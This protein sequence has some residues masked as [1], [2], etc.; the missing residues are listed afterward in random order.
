MRKKKHSYCQHFSDYDVQFFDV[1]SMNIM[2]HGHYV[3]YLEMARC[4][5]LESIGYHYDV[6]KETGFG[7]PI[8]QLELKYVKPALFRQKIRIYLSLV[9]YETCIRFD[10]RIVDLET[11]ERLT[12]GSTTQVAVD[13]RKREMQLQTPDSWQQ[14][15]QNCPS[16][17]PLNA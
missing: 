6:M 17:Q 4:A 5:F 14:A 10:Y 16:F 2:W 13:M 7:Y 12:Q 3:K 9:E 8:V 15:V 1:D 11:G